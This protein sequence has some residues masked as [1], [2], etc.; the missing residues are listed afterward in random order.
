MRKQIF[1]KNEV[2][3]DYVV[4]DIH[5]EYDKLMKELEYHKFDKSKDRLFSV[6]DLVDRGPDSVKCLELMSEDWFFS[7]QGNHEEMMINGL[8]GDGVLM[9]VQ[10]GG[11]WAMTTDHNHLD[12]LADE[13]K[14]LPYII[15]LETEKGKIGIVH[16]HCGSSDWNEVEDTEKMTLIWSRQLHMQRKYI[17]MRVKNID[18]VVVGHSP[19]G[20]AQRYGNIFFIDSGTCFDKHKMY[21]IPVEELYNEDKYINMGI[22]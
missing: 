1:K 3:I 2:G 8:T 10:N 16:A 13:I 7:V 21:I 11:R 6:G 9:W 12:E 20:K 19:V 15:E 17:S 14:Q 5:G 18:Y 4:G 22:N